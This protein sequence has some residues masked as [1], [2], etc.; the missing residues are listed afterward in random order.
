LVGVKFQA[1]IE[2]WEKHSMFTLLALVSGI[3]TLS[4][5]LFF[6]EATAYESYTIYFS[7]LFLSVEGLICARPFLIGLILVLIQF[8]M[9]F[10]EKFVKKHR[11]PEISPNILSKLGCI[12]MVISIFL[13][14]LIYLA[15]SPH[16]YWV[17]QDPENPGI[18]YDIIPGNQWYYYACWLYYNCAA[19]YVKEVVIFHVGAGF[20]CSIVMVI[21]ILSELIL[22]RIQ[23]RYYYKTYLPGHLWER[24]N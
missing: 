16:D 11:I 10:F 9:Q 1:V 21:F 17:L 6:V 13:L 12:M 20:V 18:I 23:L 3:L 14:A 15:G 2:Y 4:L 22:K 5:G 19:T 24:T 8:L 7:K